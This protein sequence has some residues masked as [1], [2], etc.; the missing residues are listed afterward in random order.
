MIIIYLEQ[1]QILVEGDPGEMMIKVTGQ[2]TFP[3]KD[4]QHIFDLNNQHFGNCYSYSPLPLEH[5]RS[6]RKY[7]NECMGQCFSKTIY[8]ASS[9]TDLWY[10]D[11]SYQRRNDFSKTTKLRRQR[12]HYVECCW[13]FYLIF[14]WMYKWKPSD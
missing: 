7:V 8:K 5:E 1:G 14:M 11:N 4:Q 12:T 9:I 10:S 3:V 6:H 13:H 2:Q